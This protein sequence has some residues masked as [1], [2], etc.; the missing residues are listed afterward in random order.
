MHHSSILQQQGLG[1]RCLVLRLLV[2]AQLEGAYF[3][4]R[5][6]LPKSFLQQR[7]CKERREVEGRHVTFCRFVL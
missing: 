5:Q 2:D 3:V 4:F 1:F 7:G 6:K